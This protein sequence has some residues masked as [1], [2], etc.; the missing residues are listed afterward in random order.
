MGIRSTVLILLA[1]ML[2][3][4]AAAA[5]PGAA[6]RDRLQSLLA[7]EQYGQAVP[8]LQQLDARGEIGA[9]DTALLLGRIYLGLGKPGKAAEFFEQAEFASLSAEAEARLGLAESKLGL[10][11]LAG[12]A[13]AAQAALRSDPDQVGAHLVLALADQRLGRSAAAVARLDK[14]RRSLIRG[15][16]L[17]AACFRS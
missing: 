13:Q 1:G 16:G 7:A 8:L 12:A 14:L 2:P 6:A 4:I 10:G 17:V 15:R 5:E 3:A 9:A 11:D